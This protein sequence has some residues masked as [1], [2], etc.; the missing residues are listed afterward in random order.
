MSRKHIAH[1]K[2]TPV[3]SCAGGGQRVS[4]SGSDF[5][6]GNVTSSDPQAVEV[7]P[8][9]NHAGIWEVPYC[10]RCSPEVGFSQ[11]THDNGSVR[12][13]SKGLG[14]SGLGGPIKFIAT[15]AGTSYILVKDPSDLKGQ[16]RL[17]AGAAPG[18]RTPHAATLP[19]LPRPRSLA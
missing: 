12:I 15:S 6:P 17:T 11:I 1:S 7:S 10:L 18:D 5:V 13:D 3:T 16:E 8:L 2:G 9:Q 19:P 4:Q 14:D